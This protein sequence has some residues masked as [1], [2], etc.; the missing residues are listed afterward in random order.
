VGPA[1]SNGLR[2]SSKPIRILIVE[3]HQLVADAL[4]A[5]LNQQPDMVVVGN[6]GSVADAAPRATELSPDIVIMDF[7]LND[8]TGADAA[9]AIWQA[10]CEASVIYFT[11]DESDTVRLA[12]IEAGASAVIYKSGA[13]AELIDAVRTVAGGGTLIPSDTIATL[14]N[15]L[16][17]ID[18]RRDKLTSREREILSLMAEGAPSREIA[19]K[20]GISY[21]TVRTHI[22]SLGGKLNCHSKLEVVAKA[23][24]LA[25]I[26]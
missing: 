25:L 26:N 14:F 24:E 15:K 8:G 20:L 9:V 23:R 17:Q 7:R 12:A 5:L 6:S 22:R 11:R 2:L 4:E 3:D 16:R 18:G 19:A 1:A 10:G 21:L 13:A